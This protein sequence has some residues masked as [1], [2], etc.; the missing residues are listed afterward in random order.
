M[1]TILAFRDVDRLLS[2]AF[3]VG[4]EDEMSSGSSSDAPAASMTAAAPAAVV[5]E[6]DPPA[7]AAATFSEEQE[8]L[9]LSAWNAMKGE[10]AADIALKFFLR[11]LLTKSCIDLM[12]FGKKK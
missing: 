12:S 5:V 9:V 1:P 8:K 7:A 3:L 6:E 11:L 10:P 2:A 4:E